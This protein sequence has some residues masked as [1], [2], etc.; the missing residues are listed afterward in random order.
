MIRRGGTTA[1]GN[2]AHR[3]RRAAPGFGVL[4]PLAITS[5]Y[6]SMLRRTTHDSKSFS[7]IFDDYRLVMRG[8]CARQKK[9]RA[10]R[11]GP[12]LGR[13]RQSHGRKRTNPLPSSMVAQVM[14]VAQ[15]QSMPGSPKKRAGKQPM[16]IK[17]AEP[18]QYPG[19][20]LIF[21]ARPASRC[22]S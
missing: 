13:K 12:S 17:K 8:V 1:A 14:N 19:K 3:R 16:H 22:E 10:R 6:I 9:G 11:H 21:P 20:P 2:P 18:A 7:P 15:R 5:N 4:A